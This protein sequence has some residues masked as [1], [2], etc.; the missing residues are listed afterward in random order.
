MIG[1]LAVGH[2][3]RDGVDILCFFGGVL[4]AVL[5]GGGILMAGFICMNLT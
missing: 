2:D 5:V 3:I 1:R 4:F